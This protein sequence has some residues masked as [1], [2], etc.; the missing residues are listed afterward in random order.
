MTY[1][2]IKIITNNYRQ[3]TGRWEIEKIVSKQGR[4][5]WFYT[6]ILSGSESDLAVL[7][8]GIKG[9][10]CSAYRETGDLA[11]ERT[12]SLQISIYTAGS[13]ERG[14]NSLFHV[15]PSEQQKS[16]KSV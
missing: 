6:Q 7:N 9:L 12:A 15:K 14:K 4:V 10:S 1:E 5:T 11:C 16:S 8:K 13:S 2:A 3:W